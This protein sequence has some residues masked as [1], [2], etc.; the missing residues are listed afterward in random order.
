MKTMSSTTSPEP[1]ITAGLL[2][3]V[4]PS[5]SPPLVN[6]KSPIKTK[7]DS[8]SFIFGEP[9]LAFPPNVKPSKFDVIRFWISSY[10]L[11][12]GQSKKMLGKAKVEKH[13]LDSLLSLPVY[14]QPS[15]S[16][17]P[18]RS[19]E[20]SLKYNLSI[21]DG[22]SD[23]HLRKNDQSEKNLAWI[24]GERKR[25]KDTF[26]V[27]QTHSPETV[28]LANICSPKR[29]LVDLNSSSVNI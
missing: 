4:P 10:D 9:L 20:R 7:Q 3:V 1:T 15:V 16:L 23:L 2:P 5:V 18:R 25:F 17:L 22:Y 12:R 13:V 19:M 21:V 8:L 14:N 28:N 29:K 6:P 27:E 11:E 26:N 24:E